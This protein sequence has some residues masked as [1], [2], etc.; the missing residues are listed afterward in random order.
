MNKWLA[1]FGRPLCERKKF[2][3]RVDEDGFLYD[4]SV[5]LDYLDFFDWLMKRSDDGGIDNDL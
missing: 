4:D 1:T 3:P 5:F 2:F